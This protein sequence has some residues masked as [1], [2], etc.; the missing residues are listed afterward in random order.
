M[1]TPQIDTTKNKAFYPS[2]ESLINKGVEVEVWRTVQVQEEDFETNEQITVYR[3][4]DEKRFFPV[5]FTNDVMAQIERRWGDSGVWHKA[6][7]NSPF[8][9]VLETFIILT[10]G[11]P[12]PWVSEIIISEAIEEYQFAL[13]IAYIV[14]LGASPDDLGKAI[15]PILG[16]GSIKDELITASLNRIQAQTDA[17]TATVKMDIPGA[18]TSDSGSSSTDQSPNSG[19]STSPSTTSPSTP[20]SNGSDDRKAKSTKRKGSVHSS[21]SNQPEKEIS[22]T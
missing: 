9:T 19:N 1:S 6:L 15:Y 16:I 2:I 10:N 4:T 13:Q 18:L 7:V 12:R 20:T 5:R 22:K 17:L 11:K 14:A 21:I 8:S 3:R